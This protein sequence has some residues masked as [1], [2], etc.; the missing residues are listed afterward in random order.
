MQTNFSGG[1]DRRHGGMCDFG[2][3]AGRCKKL[4][5][6]ADQ[7]G[8]ALRAGRHHRLCGAPAR[9]QARGLSR[10]KRRGRQPARRRL[11]HRLGCRRQ[12]DSRR[13]YV[14]DGRYGFQRDA[15]A[16]FEIAVR[17][18]QGFHAGHRGHARR[19]LADRSRVAGRA[20]GARA[21]CAREGETRRAHVRLRRRGFAVSHGGRAIQVRS[22]DRYRARPVT[23]AAALR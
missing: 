23:K 4:S 1:A 11:H 8:R 21:G 10:A 19:Q 5:G 17:C 16:L 7:A 20:V 18:G 9:R 13:L 22:E 15:R 14:V 2:S 3:R 12:G 6:P